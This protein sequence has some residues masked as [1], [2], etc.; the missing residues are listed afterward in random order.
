MY[1]DIPMMVSFLAYLQGGVSWSEE[2]TRRS[3]EVNQAS[4][5]VSGSFKFPLLASLFGMDLAAEASGSTNRDASIEST[6]ARHHTVASLFNALYQY[7]HEDD[8]VVTLT[9]ASQ[10]T[11]IRAGQLVE[12]TGEYLGNPLAA[13]L[14][15]LQQILPYMEEE[16]EA[17][18]ATAN[19]PAR[20]PPRGKHKGGPRTSPRMPDGDEIAQQLVQAAMREV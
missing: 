5:K 4:G 14:G 13:V 19:S 16:E 2:E 15:M 12:V 8:Q 10:L 3:A 17:E 7:L 9:E 18:S 6:V 11:Q 20:T 1:L